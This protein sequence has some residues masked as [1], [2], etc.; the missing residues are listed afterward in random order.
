M[1]WITPYRWGSAVNSTGLEQEL[2]SK[3]NIWNINDVT[4]KQLSVKCLLVI[5]MVFK[6]NGG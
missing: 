6:K 4:Y 1:S 3:N 2:Y 5:P